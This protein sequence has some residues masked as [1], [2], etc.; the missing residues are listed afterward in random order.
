MRPI[1]G[2]CRW[3]VT[4]F[5]TIATAINLIATIATMRAPA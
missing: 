5:G 1:T 2:I 3:L 4:G